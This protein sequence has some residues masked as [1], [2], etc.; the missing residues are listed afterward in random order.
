MW[1]NPL[2]H[3]G[4]GVEE[5]PRVPG[6]EF[7]VAG[8]S[9]FSKDVRDLRG[10]YRLAVDGADNRV[11]SGPVGHGLGTIGGDAFVEEVKAVAELT[12][13]AGGEMFE[14]PHRV[15]RV[16][17]AQLNLSGEGEVI[18]DED[19]GTGDEAGGVGLVVTVAEPDDPRVVR[20]LLFGEAHLDD[21]EVASSFV[22]EG[23]DGGVDLESGAGQLLF[24]LG[25]EIVVGE[26]KPAGGGSWCGNGFEGLSRHCAGSAVKEH[27]RHAQFLG[28]GWW[29]IDRV[30]HDDL[31]FGWLT[32]FG[33]PAGGIL[34]K[35][36]FPSIIPRF[37]PLW[38][39]D[40]CPT[41]VV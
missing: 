8:V 34:E 36:L 28:G 25:H 20:C 10:R 3:L 31:R 7:R 17:A 30:V 22:T 4:E 39:V 19:P 14:I 15:S 12:D 41:P 35:E 18:T 27:S 29:N 13:G 1:V 6:F 32:R 21:S 26:R 5:A 16:F 2:V 37:V 40:R 38:Q 9:P 33:I 23:V 11:M 24:D